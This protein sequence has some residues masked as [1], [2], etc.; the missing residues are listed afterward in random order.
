MRTQ[1][2]GSGPCY[3][4]TATHVCDCKPC[5]AC[6]LVGQGEGAGSGLLRCSVWLRLP[7]RLAV[8]S[9]VEG[10]ESG[11]AAEGACGG[12]STWCES[13]HRLQVKPIKLYMLVRCS[14]GHAA[15]VG[16]GAASTNHHVVCCTW[17][18]PGVI[19]LNQ[20]P[21]HLPLHVNT[22]N[23]KASR[24]SL[25]RQAHVYGAEALGQCGSLRGRN[26]AAQK[27]GGPILQQ[28][29][30][31]APCIRQERDGGRLHAVSAGAAGV[32]CRL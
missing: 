17:H 24:Y 20:S 13:H 9:R 12:H 11:R 15:Q 4:D 31:V 28:D 10:G 23:I 6:A 30:A 22:C 21:M 29:R 19:E 7:P 16:R 14:K 3:H 18:F 8:K 5:G 26:L 2:E 1:A 27:H 32:P 25:P